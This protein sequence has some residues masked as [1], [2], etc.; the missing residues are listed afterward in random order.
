MR[1]CEG[2]QC[3]SDQGDSEQNKKEILLYINTDENVAIN[4]VNA[5]NYVRKLNNKCNC[6]GKMNAPNSIC[7]RQNAKHVFIYF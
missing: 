1:Q 5:F 6:L 4:I 3:V 7:C 2:E